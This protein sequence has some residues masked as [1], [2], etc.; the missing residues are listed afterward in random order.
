MQ[1][2]MSCLTYCDKSS[3]VTN[4]TIATTLHYPAHTYIVALLHSYSVN[5]VLHFHHPLLY[6]TGLMI[7]DPDVHIPLLQYHRIHSGATI[8]GVSWRRGMTFVGTEK[9]REKVV[10]LRELDRAIIYNERGSD[11]FQISSVT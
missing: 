9:R 5:S 10:V 6:R 7:G 11:S 3:I 8:I 2:L 4:S 1:L